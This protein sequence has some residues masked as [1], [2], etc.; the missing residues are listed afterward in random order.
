MDTLS[1]NPQVGEIR[2]I[3]RLAN[4]PLLSRF[5][6][7]GV[8]LLDR[9]C[10]SLL[11]LLVHWPPGLYRVKV[12]G[13]ENVPSAG[14]ALLVCNHV[15]WVDGLLVWLSLRRRARF[16]IWA[17]FTKVPGVRFFLWLARVIPIDGRAGPR[18]IAR[19][20]REASDALNNGELVC[21]FAEGG[22][23]RTGFMLPFNRGFEQILKKAPVPIIPTSL[24]RL[25]GSIFSYQGGQFIWKRIQRF[26]YPVTIKFGKPMPAQS[27]AWQVRLAVQQLLAD[28]FNLRIDDHKPAHR[29]FVW[30]ASKEPWRP[31]LIDPA[32]NGKRLNYIETLIAARLIAHRLQRKVHNMQ[33]VGLLLPT[34]VG[35]ALANIAVSLLGKTAVNLNYTAS[36]EAILSAVQQC[37]IR[38]VITSRVFQEK[39]KID[40]GG[41]V[42][43]I[44]L[45]DI[46][47]RMS[48]FRQ[49]KMYLSIL[50]LPTWV[51]ERFVLRLGHQ[52]SE[53]LATVI[54]S[55]GTTGD[56]KGVMLSHHNIVS[57]IESTCQAIDPG[58]QD[59]LLNVLPFFHSFGYLALWIPLLVGA[60]AVCYPDPRQAKEIGEFCRRF[61]C[62]LFIMTPTFLRF[63]IR[64][65]D[66]GDFR[67]VRMLITG[68]EKLP[69]TLADEFQ[70]KFGVLPMEGYGCTELS[71]VAA[72]NV[73]DWVDEQGNRQTGH[74]PGAIGQPIP[75]VAAKIVDPNTFEL[76]PPGQEGLLLIYGPNVMVGYLNRPELTREVIRDGW[77]VT[78]DIAKMDEDGFLTITDRLSRFSKVAG[79]MI[80]HQRI[81]DELHKLLGT[82]DRVCAV[83]G[84]PD[85]KKGE[86]LIVLHT[87]LNGVTVPQLYERLARSGLPNLWLPDLKNFYEVHDL[88]VLGSGKLD[89]QRVKKVAVEMASGKK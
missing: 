12:V 20:L 31:C 10:R 49:L 30:K 59:R 78:G 21:I 44:Y 3:A 70:K 42:S 68:A 17:P 84:I 56:P 1:Q 79:E 23:T 71:P 83:T 5:K 67:T 54:F 35:G 87:A 64:R 58:P 63:F 32:P 73:P 65:C 46:A 26:P 16:I 13:A 72:V 29:Q 66:P 81:E 80:P 77:Y 53:D 89:L 6:A 45:E 43:Q 86:K 33:M 7:I 57:N 27:K 36:K 28:C 9:F 37:N 62:T 88:P 74:K 76:L 2:V 4:S 40:L 19:A 24:D 25:W 14:P 18:S 50:L 41:N 60:S 51:L 82:T 47:A 48:K 15:S 8:W 22:I 11:W 55:S 34:S 85:E 52:S 75:G 39:L 69:R 61:R 38:Q